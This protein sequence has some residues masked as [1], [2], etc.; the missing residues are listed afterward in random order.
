MLIMNKKI[1]VAAFCIVSFLLAAGCATRPAGP[2]VYTVALF[3]DQQY[4]AREETLFP[5]LV[6]DINAA[7][8][9]FVVH[10]GDIKGG[11]NAP[12][13][14]ALFKRRYNEFQRI[15]SALIFTPGDNDWV[16][17]RRPTNGSMNPLERLEKLREIF[18]STNL[19]LGEKPIPLTRQ[20]DAFVG[21]PI[22]SRYRENAFWVYRGIVFVTLNIQ[23]SNDNVGFDK[24]NDAEQ[25]ERARANIEW[26]NIAMNR[27]RGTDIV[28]LAIF[29]QANPGF[30]DSVD[31]VAKS[32]FVPFLTAFEK[33]AS[34]FAKPILFAH[35]DTHTYRVD[36][37]YKSPLD[38][39]SMANVT[40]VETD[41]SP[42]VDWTRITID[43]NNKVKPFFIE[44]GNFVAPMQPF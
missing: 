36:A 18:F 26:L 44:R 9:A 7:K 1:V 4:S 6:D 16:D 19:S 25:I 20:S 21:D 42:R 5:L 12:C 34:A 10:V 2:S 8:P 15:K 3:G 41:G 29:F 31:V 32:G 38:K 14:D 33:E 37:P 40:R 24:E 27:A 17:C 35:G 13:T 30:E 11:G 28:G 22:L 43:T 39:R 23:G